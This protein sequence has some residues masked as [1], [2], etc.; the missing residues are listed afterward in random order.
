[1]KHLAPALLSLAACI[2][3]SPP[4]PTGPEVTSVVDQ[5]EIPVSFNTQLDVLFVI[6]SSPAMA[7]A[8]TRLIAEYR[9]MIDVLGS[10]VGGLPDVHI[11]V[12][13]MDARDHGRLRHDAFLADA[14]RFAWRRERNYTGPLVDAFLPLAEV[15][16]TGSSVT[17]PFDAMLRATDPATNPGFV[18]DQAYLA[19]VVLTAGDDQGA[20][21]PTEVAHALKSLKVDPY[22]IMVSGA[23][24]ACA[25]DGLT[26]TAAPRLAAL[27]DQFPNRN[28]HVSLCDDDLSP[29]VALT[30]QLFRYALGQPCIE[31]RLAQPRECGAWLVDP[32]SE[33]QVVLPECSGPSADR[34]WTLRPEDVACGT[35]GMG[36]HFQPIVFPFAARLMFE[37]VVATD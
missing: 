32:D 8:Q 10:S 1:M 13:T 16:A 6:D 14:T 5:H 24:G 15:G 20:M 35:G 34:C 7:P 21:L 12:T 25:R 4:P 19:V 17:E 29:L 23:F 31:S 37:C 2:T 22:K 11:G 36:L 26:A 9:K 28:T 30:A 27:L 18:R 33:D 3:E